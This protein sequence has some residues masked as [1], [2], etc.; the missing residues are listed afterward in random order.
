MLAPVTGTAEAATAC[1][2]EPTPDAAREVIDFW[3]AAG[4]SR[5]FAKDPAFDRTFRERFASLYAAA[6]AGELL[7]WAA[8]PEGALGLILLLDQYPRNSFRGT[9]RMYATDAM[10]RERADAAIQAGH[11]RCV[12][13][14]LA[15]FVYLPFGH[16]ESLADQERSVELA[17]RLGAPHLE[18]AEHHRDIVREFGRF[19]HR[20]AI[21]GRLSS[22][23]EQRYLSNGG[24][25]G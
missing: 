23:A 12:P 20:N 1:A 24:Y 11:D 22:A 6:A 9:A 25:Q 3:R 13:A 21:L 17:R 5:W 7:A 19:P 18:H 16:S 14:E 4:K 2:G 10:A 8:T 15:M